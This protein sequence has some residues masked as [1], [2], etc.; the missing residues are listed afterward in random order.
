MTSGLHRKGLVIVYELERQSERRQVQKI[1]RIAD[2][3]A[4]EPRAQR[5]VDARPLREK[6]AIRL[7]LT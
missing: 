4:D 7:W 5:R 3:E 1:R 6:V 2:D